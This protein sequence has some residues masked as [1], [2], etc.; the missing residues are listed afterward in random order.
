MLVWKIKLFKVCLILRNVTSRDMC[1][2]LL[3][4]M[5]RLA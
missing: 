1:K 5:L 3:K 4:V 2:A